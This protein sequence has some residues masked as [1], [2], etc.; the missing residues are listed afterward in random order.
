MAETFWDYEIVIACGIVVDGRAWAED[1]HLTHFTTPDDHQWEVT[2]RKPVNERE[3]VA[4]MVQRQIEH[5]YRLKIW[6]TGKG[7]PYSSPIRLGI[8]G[9]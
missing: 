9:Y 7:D 1:G 4:Q 3:R 8:S 5:Q 6:D 2:M